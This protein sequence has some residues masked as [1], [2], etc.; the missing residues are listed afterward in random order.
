MIKSYGS[1]QWK[2]TH[3][4]ACPS[5]SNPQKRV[6]T[7]V[8]IHENNINSFKESALKVVE[9]LSTKLSQESKNYNS[10]SLI[11]VEYVYH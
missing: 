7:L 10:I 8:G 11:L 6:N 5:F 4:M 1:K 2:L 3:F 9:F